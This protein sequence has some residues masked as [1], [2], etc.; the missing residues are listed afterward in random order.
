MEFSVTIICQYLSNLILFK[1]PTNIL[2]RTHS[3]Q[4]KKDEASEDPSVA[5]DTV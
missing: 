4:K 2:E 3:S 1:E 5:W